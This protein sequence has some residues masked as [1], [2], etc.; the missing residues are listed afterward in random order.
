MS[1][2]PPWATQ[3]VPASKRKKKKK[4]DTTAHTGGAQGRCKFAL[5]SL[6]VPLTPEFLQIDEPAFEQVLKKWPVLLFR[7]SWPFP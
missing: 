7:H 5:F 6:Y 2:R 3:G 1:S 4:K